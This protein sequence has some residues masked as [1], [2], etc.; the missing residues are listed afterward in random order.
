[1]TLAE[2]VEYTCK[3]EWEE[4]SDEEKAAYDYDYDWYVS[5]TMFCVCTN[6]D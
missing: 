2:W 4:M 6:T 1:M 3:I 5:D